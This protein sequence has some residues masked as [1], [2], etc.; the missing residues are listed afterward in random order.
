MSGR[1]GRRGS[2][3]L[4]SGGV[5][6]DKAEMNSDREN[7][8]SVSDNQLIFFLQI[9]TL[10]LQTRRNYFIFQDKQCKE[11]SHR[12]SRFLSIFQKQEKRESSFLIVNNSLLPRQYLL[13]QYYATTIRT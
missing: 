7:R 8:I 2:S 13:Y 12:L 10:V 1:E 6:A 11:P 5:S 9:S 3:C 4:D